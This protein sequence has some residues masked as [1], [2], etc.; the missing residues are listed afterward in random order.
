VVEYVGGVRDGPLTAF[1]LQRGRARARVLPP[2]G[3]GAGQVARLTALLTAGGA[4]GSLDRDLGTR[5]L[6]PVVAE[7]APGVRRLVIIPDG[8]LHRLPFDALRLAD[9]RLAVERFAITM[10]P[11]AGVLQEL[12]RRAAA[13]PATGPTAHI[14]ALGDPRFAVTRPARDAAGQ[15]FIEAFAAA[16]GLPRLPGSAREARLVG[17]YA[18]SAE[19]RLGDSASEAYLERARLDRFAVIHL[20]THAI[21]DDRSVARTAIALTPGPNDDGFVAP[22]ELAALPLH[23]DLVVLSACRTAAG[24]LVAGEGIQGLTAPLLQAGARSVVATRWRIGDRAALGIV[25]PFYDALAAGL[26]VGDALQAAKLAALRRGAPARAWVTFTA[27]GDPLVRVP[28]HRPRT[29]WQAWAAGLA[30]VVVLLGA[31]GARAAR[32]RSPAA[33][34]L[35]QGVRQPHDLMAHRHGPE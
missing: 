26:P 19:V 10:A 25:Q 33:G 17:R 11:S 8:P 1:V 35:P 6:D 27:V 22:A 31:V 7:L 21:V 13:A 30:G 34:R 5:L 15:A 24:V 23:A 16:G 14:L 20:A 4:P 29:P 9:G 18:D 28:L 3:Q 2:L 32:E 12:W